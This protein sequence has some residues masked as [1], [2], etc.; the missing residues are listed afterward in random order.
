M[1]WMFPNNMCARVRF[2]VQW[3][4][5][6]RDVAISLGKFAAVELAVDTFKEGGAIFWVMG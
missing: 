5:I 1:L 2:V 6:R 3:V 4:T